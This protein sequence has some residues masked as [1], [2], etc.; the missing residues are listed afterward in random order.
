MGVRTRE[1]VCDVFD[2]HA[3]V[4]DKPTWGRG[5][6][7][8]A[9]SKGM[10]A[11]GGVYVVRAGDAAVSEQVPSTCQTGGSGTVIW[12]EAVEEGGSGSAVHAAAVSDGV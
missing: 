6:Y 2:A 1:G 3:T 12:I 7:T 11:R 9:V 4:E 5:R 8:V 10:E